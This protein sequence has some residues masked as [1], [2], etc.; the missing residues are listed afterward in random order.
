MD[1]KQEDIKRTYKDLLVDSFAMA[2]WIFAFINLLKHEIF[3]GI[4][5]IFSGFMV[6]TAL[7]SNEENLRKTVWTRKEDFPIFLWI[8]STIVIIGAHEYG[9]VSPE[10]TINMIF[11][12]VVRKFLIYSITNPFISL[13]IIVVIMMLFIIKIKDEKEIQRKITGLIGKIR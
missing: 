1:Y 13:S 7:H 11:P 5:G 2:I 9:I 6:I 8:A 10:E 3:W 12:L 4:I